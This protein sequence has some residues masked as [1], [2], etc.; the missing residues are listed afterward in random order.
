MT[1]ANAKSVPKYFPI[2]PLASLIQ[3]ARIHRMKANPTSEVFALLRI[4][5]RCIIMAA[6]QTSDP[7]ATLQAILQEC[8][9][10]SEVEKSLGI[11]PNPV[12]QDLLENP[13]AI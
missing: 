8:K 6:I 5:D 4:I 13:N 12:I 11:T 1:N 9:K 7:L 10:V 2:F 3:L